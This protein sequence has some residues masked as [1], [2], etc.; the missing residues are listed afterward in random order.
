MTKTKLEYVWLDGYMP[1]PN[2]RSKT[3]IVDLGTFNLELNKIPMWSFDG[4]STRQAL[5][6]SSDCLLKPVS[7]YPDPDRN[8]AFL[9]LAEV[10]NPDGTPHES[11]FRSRIDDDPDFW[12][13]FEQEYTLTKNGKPLG[14]PSDGYPEP[15]GKYY[16]SVGF[17]YAIGR[18]IVDE[19]LDRCLETGIDITGVNAEVMCGQ[20]EFQCFA[21]GAKKAADDLWMSRYLLYRIAEKYGVKVDISPKPVTGDWNGSGCHT[22]FSNKAMRE[23]G[24]EDLFR[25]ICESLGRVHHKHIEDYGSDNHHR[26]TGLHETQHIDSFTYGVS[27][28]GASVRIPISTVENGWKGYL[29]DRRP[30]SNIDPYRVTARIMNTVKNGV[31]VEV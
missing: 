6:H 13:G 3:K 5:G 23:E 1:E 24:G 31:A 25:S 2:L 4:S 10:M 19:H 14:F 20:W 18:H 9:V 12:I 11:N 28:R 7:L 8:N 21:K 17:P 26:L 30:A 22:N 29:E 16:C 27:D 15:Q